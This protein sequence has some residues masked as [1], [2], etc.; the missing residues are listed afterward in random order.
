MAIKN[1]ELKTWKDFSNMPTQTFIEKLN[2]MKNQHSVTNEDICTKAKI[3]PL[4][5]HLA[6]T[7]QR[8]LDRHEIVR[9]AKFFDIR[10]D[11][12]TD[13]L[14]RFVDENKLS[15]EWQERFKNGKGVKCYC[16]ASLDA[17]DLTE[18]D[19]ENILKYL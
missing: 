18:E 1:C 12:F 8:P 9:L 7:D 15:P 6:E 17:P 3:K 5:L 19:L 4:S 13:D 10:A 2:Y 14:I 16:V 11:F